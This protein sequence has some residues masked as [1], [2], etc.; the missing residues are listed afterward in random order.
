MNLVEGLL[1]RVR[2]FRSVNRMAQHWGI[3]VPFLHR[4]HLE[5]RNEVGALARVAVSIPCM[6]FE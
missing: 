2:S 6:R 3:P 1:G 4:R 5:Y